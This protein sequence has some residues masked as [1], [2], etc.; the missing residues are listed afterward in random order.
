M[1]I[2]ILVERKKLRG[3]TFVTGFHGIGETG[4]IA[5]SYLIHALKADRIGFIRVE[6]PPPFVTTSNVGII[7]P[8]EI[9]KKGKIV[10]FKLEFPPHRTE[11]TRLLKNIAT[12]IVKTRFK[13]AILIGGLDSTFKQDKMEFR[14]VPTSRYLQK[15]KKIR[16]HILD[17]GLFVY[18]PLA[19]LLS[20]FEILKFPAIAIL[21]YANAG[22]ADPG[23]AAI[24]IKNIAKMHGI[25]VNV[26]D[27]ERDAKEIE[28][29]VNK[30]I[31]Q[32]KDSLKG[33]YV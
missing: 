30:K 12:W 8:F 25:K 22:R 7:T 3:S 2:E 29:E 5:V 31:K 26:K 27:L 20:E 4:Y 6:R 17:Q 9:Y 10:L 21:P 18:G 19:T 32:A 13:D 23:A 16:H 24:A 14:S 15:G 1:S 11:E 33:V 28:I